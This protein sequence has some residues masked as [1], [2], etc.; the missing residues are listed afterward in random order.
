[1]A[2][3]PPILY[4]ISDLVFKDSLVLPAK[5]PRRSEELQVELNT[6]EIG[7]CN[8][9]RKTLSRNKSTRVEAN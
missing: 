7:H 6:V 5:E 1:M 2:F 9:K 3:P 8:R 4:Q